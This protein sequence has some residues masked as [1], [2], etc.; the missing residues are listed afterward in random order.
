MYA[1]IETGGKQYRVAAGDVIQV[2]RLAGDKGGEIAFDKVLMTGTE[3][4]VTVGRPHVAGATV[5]AE[6]VDQARAPKIIVFKKERRK[7]H[8]RKKGHRQDITVLRITGI[9]GA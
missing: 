7:N 2:E 4:A 6:I 8:R 9:E 3:G 5:K 1:V